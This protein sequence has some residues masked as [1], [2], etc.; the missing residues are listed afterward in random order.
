MY[1]HQCE[2]LTNRA[3]S[4][5]SSN[6]KINVALVNIKETPQR[7]T[8]SFEMSWHVGETWGE[9]NICDVTG[10]SLLIANYVSSAVRPHHSCFEAS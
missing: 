9:G 3:K 7:C 5:H 6:P 2:A 8:R 10:V 4:N 1:D